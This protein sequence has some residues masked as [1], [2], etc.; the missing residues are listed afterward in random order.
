MGD[1][2]IGELG[3]DVCRHSTQG[4][5]N[6]SL[7]ALVRQLAASQGHA[8][9]ALTLATVAIS[10]RCVSGRPDGLA[11]LGITGWR[12]YATLGSGRA[13]LSRASISQRKSEHDNGN[14]ECA[15]ISV[16]N[17]ASAVSRRRDA[18]AFR[19]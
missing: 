12:R 19:G 16:L 10:A 13:L 4:I 7:E 3:L 6:V 14:E 2:L 8:Q 1:L 9:A 15:H 11:R 18:E 5:P 17:A